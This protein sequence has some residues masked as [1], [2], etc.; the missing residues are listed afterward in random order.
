M[1]LQKLNNETEEAFLWRLG[2]AHDDGVISE[3]WDDIALAINKELYGDDTQQYKSSSAYRKV[4][5]N[6]RR[7]YDA[8]VFENNTDEKH[9][10]FLQKQRDL[11]TKERRKYYDQRRE[12]NKILTS[13][14]REEHL[15]DELVK[16]AERIAVEKPLEFSGED[17]TTNTEREALL[18]F[19]DWHYGMVT[20]NIWNYYNTEVCRSRVKS[21]VEYATAYIVKNG[22]STLHIALLGDAAHGAI[23]VGCR[24][25]AEEDVCDQIM[26][27]SEL[28]AEAINELSRHVG[29]VKVYHC[30]GNHL[31]TVQKK[32]DSKH[33]DNME[34]LIPWWLKQR[35]AGNPRISVIDSE[36]A[37]FTRMNILGAEI[38]CVHGDLD[39]FKE[40][41]VTVNTIFTRL[42]GEDID[43]TISADKH[44]LEEFEAF[45]IESIMVRSLCG[46]DEYANNKR[47]YSEAGQT[48][49]IFN[50]DYGR[51]C[52][53][54]IPLE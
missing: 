19:S 37:E 22:I 41:G 47:L 6:A 9:I 51:E 52:T 13:E 50:S 3:G 45:G 16:V 32:D 24:V 2:K 4:Y 36:Y 42:Y 54:H 39:T 18:V 43:Y 21:L 11:L 5:Q 30:Y 10:A 46:T 53:Y 44:H 31:R 29:H 1:Y 15:Y 12:Y 20:D 35:L 27:V 40:L 33:S 48:L 14:A 17:V 23:H 7:M 8:G 34:K 26:H 38:C 28:M 25:Q 49:I